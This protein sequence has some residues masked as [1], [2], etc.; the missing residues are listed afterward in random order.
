MI[1]SYIELLIPPIYVAVPGIKIG[2]AN[3]VVIAI[4][5]NF[6]IKYASVISFVRVIL[7]SLLFGTMF[8]FTYSISGAVVSL[9]VMLL[10]KKL[11]SFSIIGVSIAG[12]VAHNIGQVAVAV[13][14]FER[15][16]LW[17]YISVLAVTGT[18]SGIFVGIIGGI[19]AK[20]LSKLKL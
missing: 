15:V 20:S 4:L 19:I 9:L 7:T 8:T 3:I 18:V 1:F 6:G 5:Y 10:L 11:D 2:L 12:G 13:F 14:L 16:E 17:Y